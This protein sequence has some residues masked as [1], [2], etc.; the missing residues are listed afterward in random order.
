M[1][2]STPIWLT[3]SHNVENITG[4]KYLMSKK[5]GRLLCLTCGGQAWS[6]LS[7]AKGMGMRE[8]V[9]GM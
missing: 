3:F 8:R 9:L 6:L 1:E 7:Y 2:K 5:V 4:K